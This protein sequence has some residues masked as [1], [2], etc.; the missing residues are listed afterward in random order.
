MG[1][2]DCPYSKLIAFYFGV[3]CIAFLL[4]FSVLPSTCVFSDPLYFS[5]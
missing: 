2:E 5:A 1:V 3:V 4:F